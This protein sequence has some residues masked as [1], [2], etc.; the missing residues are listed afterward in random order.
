MPFRPWGTTIVAG[1]TC[2]ESIDVPPGAQI[3]GVVLTPERMPLKDA[4]I[5]LTRNGPDPVGFVVARTGADAR[6]STF[7]LTSSIRPKASRTSAC[8]ATTC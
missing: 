5:F 2:H 1:D 4:S 7:R 8:S 6:S 3:E